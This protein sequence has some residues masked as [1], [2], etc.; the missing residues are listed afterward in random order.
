MKKNTKVILG[1]SLFTAVA[2]FTAG[3][4]HE[5]KVIKKLTTDIDEL[6]E[7]EIPAEDPV[8]ENPAEAE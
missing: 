2:A 8:A 3:V 7:E 1:L 5:L 6:P 4:V